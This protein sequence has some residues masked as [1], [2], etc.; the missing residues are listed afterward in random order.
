MYLLNSVLKVTLQVTFSSGFWSFSGSKVGLTFLIYFAESNFM[1]LQ[2]KKKLDTLYFPSNQ[3]PSP[4]YYIYV[5]GIKWTAFFGH[6]HTEKS[7]QDATEF[8]Q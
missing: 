5:V 2:L 7:A 6:G 3:G 8:T 1:N 4:G